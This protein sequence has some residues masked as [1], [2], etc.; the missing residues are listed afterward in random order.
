MESSRD[1]EKKRLKTLEEELRVLHQTHKDVLDE[2]VALKAEVEKSVE[3]VVKALVNGYGRC[4]G[5]VSSTGFDPSGHSFEDYIH[6]YAANTFV[7]SPVKP[8]NP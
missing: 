7:Q 5:R 3:D 4:L 1:E 2:N 8:V 6:D